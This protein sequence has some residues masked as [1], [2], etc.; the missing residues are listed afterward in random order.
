SWPVISWS[1]MDYYGRPK[2][3]LYMAKHFF[4]P[5]LVSPYEEDGKVNVYIVSDL[6]ANKNA[7][8]EVR[9]MN[10]DGKLLWSKTSNEKIEKL[11]SHIALSVPE[12][13]LAKAGYDP[14]KT[15]I[16]AKLVDEKGNVLSSNELYFKRPKDLKYDKAP[17]A[18]DLT[19]Q[20][21]HYVLKISSPTL[22]PRV[23]VTFGDEDVS[24]SD[25][26][27]DVLPNEPAYITIKSTASLEKLKSAL[28][29]T[30]LDQL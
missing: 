17:I 20:S 10:F 1:T 15:F 11:S 26:F 21:D 2:A 16:T 6:P 13:A 23:E 22:A 7:K 12:D 24:F 30:A 4:A 3:G 27:I 28:K 19:K 5:V 9:L 29:V 25:N 14:G 8:L 18:T